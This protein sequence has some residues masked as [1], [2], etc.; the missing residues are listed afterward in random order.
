MALG[1]LAKKGKRRIPELG[2]TSENAAQVADSMG[3]ASRAAVSQA[4]A[5]TGAPEHELSPV[6][7]QLQENLETLTSEAQRLRA[8]ADDILNIADAPK[9]IKD[10]YRGFTKMI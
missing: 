6:N 3:D 10:Q 5:I 8:E 7:Q 9:K 4:D 1:S 2:R